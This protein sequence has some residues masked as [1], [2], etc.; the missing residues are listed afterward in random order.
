[1]I[2]PLPPEAA[3]QEL[4]PALP[5]FPNCILI[6]LLEEAV[7]CPEE[8]W[9]IAHEPLRVAKA[10]AMLVAGQGRTANLLIGLMGLQQEVEEREAVGSSRV[11]VESSGAVVKTQEVVVVKSVESRRQRELVVACG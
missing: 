9:K 11:G 3:G 4:G 5:H 8:E 2:S 6:S 1:M 10:V 7:S